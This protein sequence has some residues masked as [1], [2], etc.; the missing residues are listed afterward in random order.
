MAVVRYGSCPGW[1]LS[2]M[3]VVR[4][5]SCPVWQ[6]SVW[7]LSV[8]QLSVWQL[9][10]HGIFHPHPLCSEIFPINY[11]LPFICLYFPY[12]LDFPPIYLFLLSQFNLPSRLLLFTAGE[13]VPL[14][15]HQNFSLEFM[16]YFLV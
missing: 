13:K 4:D 10:V 12:R 11:F 16:R 1:Q 5:G 14:S 8:R 9:S 15:L 7:Q 6:L 2:V 3:A